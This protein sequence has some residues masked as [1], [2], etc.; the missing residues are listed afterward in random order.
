MKLPSILIVIGYRNLSA[1]MV[2]PDG[3]PEIVKTIDFENDGQTSVPL[4]DWSDD[5]RC[6][7]TV[8]DQ[9][10]RVLDRYQPDSWGLAC[11]PELVG[12]VTRWLSAGQRATLDVVKQID[13]ETVEISNVCRVFDSTAKDYATAKEHC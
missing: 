1:Y 12:K 4:V 7:W 9:I 3:L 6:E 2:L 8:A 13:V 5:N 11:P 10:S